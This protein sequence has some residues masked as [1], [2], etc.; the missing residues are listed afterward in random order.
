[1]KRLAL[2]TTII[3]AFCCQVTPQTAKCPAY[4][5]T[6]PMGRPEPD[7]KMIFKARVDTPEPE[8]LI[9][10][11]TI[12][13]GELL[14]GQGTSTI[15]VKNDFCIN[16]NITATVEIRGLPVNCPYSGSASIGVSH[17]CGGSGVL[18]DDYGRMPFGKEKLHLDNAVHHLRNDP[19]HRAVFVIYPSKKSEMAAI[20]RRAANIT[21][22]LR[23][24]GISTKR[25]KFVYGPEYTY[26]TKIWMVPDGADD[27]TI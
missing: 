21:K 22:Y 12:S 11:W 20:R 18:I 23:N 14:K 13:S 9:Y 7:G 2:T 25:F 1:M 19:H 15:N 8:K 3:F 6:G 10:H 5:I 26:M 17:A 16:P 27:P 4:D 24:R